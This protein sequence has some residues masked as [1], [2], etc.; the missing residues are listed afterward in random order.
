M[1]EMTEYTP[2][3]PS[4]VDLGTPD[5]DKTVAFY[6]AVFGWDIP[7]SPNADQTG[8]YR[9]ATSGGRSVGGVMP[10]MQEGQPPVWS[11]YVSV[12]DADATV[13]KVTEAG[14]TVIAPPMDVMDLGRMAVFMD[15]TGAVLGVW[16]PMEMKGAQL[17]NEPVSV[18]WNELNTRD[19]EAAQEFYAAVFGWQAEMSDEGGV[20]YV[21]FT[22]ADGSR[23]AGM[24]DIGRTEMPDEIP[25]HWLVYF[26]VADT[27]STISEAQEN[28]GTLRFGPVDIPIGRFAVLTD[29]NGSAFA[30]ATLSR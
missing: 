8:G 23:V 29:P 15:P 24:M 28:G 13:A 17:V 4:W 6:G 18:T 10:L 5:M 16:Q 3:T 20:G 22:R 11:T 19:P 14:G 9:T 1:P 26:A 7:E 2:G 12:E 30:V 27:D 25:A 21:M